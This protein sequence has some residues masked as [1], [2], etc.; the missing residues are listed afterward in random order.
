MKRR[1]F[2]RR[3]WGYQRSAVDDHLVTI[4]TTIE[5]LKALV[6]GQENARADLV[7]R[8]TRRSV[9]AIM[10][11]ANSEA[12]EIIA[13]ARLEAVRS[14]VGEG[15]IDLRGSVAPSEPV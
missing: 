11:E 15:M 7:L 8:A 9:E 13:E 14:R 1:Q 3:I 10:A 12:G 2:G 6:D 5:E 4:D